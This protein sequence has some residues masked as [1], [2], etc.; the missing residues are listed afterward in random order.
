LRRAL[1]V[2]IVATEVYDVARHLLGFTMKRF[3]SLFFV[4]LS[5]LATGCFDQST[6]IKAPPADIETDSAVEHAPPAKKQGIEI[7]WEV[8]GDPVDGFIIRYGNVPSALT[9]EVTISMSDIRQERD[10]EFGPVF[11]YLI[12]DIAPTDKIFVSIAAV[13]GNE[14]SNFS[15]VLEA[16]QE[17]K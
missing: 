4:T 16:Q 17:A 8:P 14:V 2:S 3:L 13:K 11:R 5:L 15:E 1:G 6:T 10:P 12:R 9:K 7:T